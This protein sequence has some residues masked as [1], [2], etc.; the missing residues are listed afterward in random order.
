MIYRVEM[1][2]QSIFA[3]TD[4]LSLVSPSLDMGLNSAGS[5]SFKMPYEHSLY[6]LPMLMTSDVDVYEGDSLVWFG[7]V[8]EISDEDMNKN[9][10]VYCEGAYSFFNDTI[11]RPYQ[12][13]DTT[14]RDY[15]SYIITHHND[16]APTNRR[17]T[18]GTVTMTN[19]NISISLDYQTS[20]A[21]L[22][23]CLN[24]FGGY[25][26]FRK[27]NGVNYIDWFEEI[28]TISPQPV[29]YA[30]N[31]VNLSKFMNG[32]TIYTSIIPLGKEINGVKTTIA[33]VND[34]ID[35][36]DSPLIETFGRIT[37]IVEWDGIG[38]PAELKEYAQHWLTTQQFSVMRIE[39]EAAE[40][41]YLDS[42]YRP[43]ITGQLVHVFSQPHGVDVNL[44]IAQIK[45]DLDNPVKKISI[46]SKDGGLTSM[47]SGGSSGSYKGST[48]GGGGG[49]GGS[50]VVIADLTQA[51]YDELP[52][53]KNYNNVIYFI[54][55]AQ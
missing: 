13:E 16:Y 39:A 6:D 24:T 3:Y 34:G 49:G 1:D 9:K 19:Q 15:F 37:K 14:I 42:E 44:P 48:G 29:Q 54:T 5:F 21:A 4:E 43:F 41:F 45:V 33:S 7:R 40:L 20:K 32:A 55:D 12:D 2:G 23:D 38:S 22:D 53:F 52:E 17:F 36:L 18:I 30:L 27:E 46:G 50:D 10:T 31:L 51:Q 26:K 47:V 8:S 11:L 28:E 35:Y 25:F